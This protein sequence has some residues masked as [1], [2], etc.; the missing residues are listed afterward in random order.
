MGR[1]W[2]S[3]SWAE[4]EGGARNEDARGGKASHLVG[5]FC[6]FVGSEDLFEVVGDKNNVM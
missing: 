3:W 1:K 6:L 2:R 5:K 4:A